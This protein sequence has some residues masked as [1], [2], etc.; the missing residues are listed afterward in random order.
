MRKVSTV[1]E[2]M[3]E[4]PLVALHGRSAESLRDRLWAKLELSLPGAMKDRV[5]LRMVEDAEAAGVLA[6]GGTIVES[7]SGTLA[8]GLARVGALKGYRVIIVTDP[9]LDALTRAKLHALGATVE[10]VD[11][12]HPTGGWQLSRLERL[13]QILRENPGAVWTCQY[14]NPSNAAAY[15]QE[16]AN[17]LLAAFGADLGA[18]VASVGSGG[19]L[20]GTARALKREL[21]GLRV[22][23]VDAVGSCLFHQPLKKRLQSGHGNNIVPG[24]LDYRIVDEVH[25]LSDGEAFTG[26]RELAR[27]E[28]IFAGGSSGAV[29]IVASWIAGRLGPG[30]QVAAIL[31]DRGDRYCDTI[32][33]DLFLAEHGLS[34]YDVPAAP[35]PIRYGLDTAERWSCAELPRDGSL[36]Y[37]AA[38]A[39]RT[40]ELARDLGLTGE[41][42]RRHFVFVESNTTGTGRTA[43]ERLLREG[44]RVTFL[45]RA[46]EKYPFLAAGADRLSVIPA[47]TN[48]VDQ[49]VRQVEEVRR[50]C[51]IDALLTFSD[52]YVAIVA[53]AAARLGLRYLDPGVAGTCRDKHATR[54]ALRRSGLPVP[55]FRLLRSLEEAWSASQEV[56]YPCVLKPVSESS[57]KGV[58]LVRD[59]EELLAHFR[60]VHGWRENARHQPVEGLVLLESLLEGPEYSVET[61]TLERGR[62][63]VVGVTAKHL[64]APPRFVETGHDFPSQ[65]EADREAALVRSAL[66]ALDALGYDFGPA[67]TE[68]RLTSDGPVVVEV[69]PRLAGGMIPE[70]VFNALGVDLVAALFAQLTGGEVD[71]APKRTEW[72]SI[73]FVIAPQRGRLVALRGVDEARQL[74][75][76]REVSLGKRVGEEVQPAEDATHRLGYVI[77]GGPDPRAVVR[78]ADAALACL[79]VTV[80]PAVFPE[81][82]VA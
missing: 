21:P 65:I 38:E 61:F 74:S 58:R 6:P 36:P 75:W 20:C 48:D 55:G 63:H 62:T 29:Y 64:S 13:G 27:R 3:K 30:R 22:V 33:S 67:H 40:I 77:T 1:L 9:R 45:S 59:A 44:E 46:P 24:N 80:A 14:D 19:S 60:E 43:L 73:R 69:N 78:A 7:S 51:P 76:V 54:E 50:Q 53:E 41:R 71:L 35:Q 23:A 25:W 2:L 52:Y 5:A 28:G 42:P 66:A 15:E 49:V 10:V 18:L 39:P 34:E 26:C 31:P 81:D 56:A 12:Y 4:S 79:E 47:E 68:I 37:H 17:E 32:Y 11:S 70:L 16:M 72:S 57:S 82:E 8:E